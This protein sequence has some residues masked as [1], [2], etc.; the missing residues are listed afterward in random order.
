MSEKILKKKVNTKTNFLF[1]RHIDLDRRVIR[2]CGEVGHADPDEFGYIPRHF[3]F[4]YVD[5]A[6][7][8]L[9]SRGRGGI[10]VYINSLGGDLYEAMAIIGRLKASPCYITTIGFGCAMSAG[11]L[12]L[13]AGGRTRKMDKYCQLMLHKSSYGVS[14]GHDLIEE[15]V[16]QA[17]QENSQMA[18]ILRDHSNESEIFWAENLKKTNLYLSVEKCE[19]YGL[20]DKIL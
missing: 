11:A 13:V 18:E 12:I 3:T 8:E 17:S 10:A 14:G 7:S 4:D 20:I 5:S 6:L 2:L 19:A 16:I 15:E 9:E 1:N